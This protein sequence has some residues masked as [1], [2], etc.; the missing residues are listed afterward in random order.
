MPTTI[1]RLTP[2]V[3]EGSDSV[4]FDGVLLDSPVVWRSVTTGGSVILGSSA[5]TGIVAGVVIKGAMAVVGSVEVGD[6]VAVGRMAV[7]DSVASVAVGV[8]TIPAV[9][10]EE[11]V[12]G[13]DCVVV[14]TEGSGVVGDGRDCDGGVVRGVGNSGVVLGSA[15]HGRKNIW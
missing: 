4:G 8:S 9:V 15:M 5:E 13:V 12:S 14:A 1:P 7:E 6:K 10:A 2:E 3:A 11:V